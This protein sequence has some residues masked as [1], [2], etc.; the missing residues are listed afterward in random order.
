[1]RIEKSLQGKAVETTKQS[2]RESWEEN[3]LSTRNTYLVK[4]NR[5]NNLFDGVDMM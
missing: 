5:Q 2:K 1:M 4:I 3:S